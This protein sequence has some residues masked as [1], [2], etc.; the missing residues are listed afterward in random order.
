MAKITFTDISIENLGPFRER[1]TL[2]LSVRDGK[3]VILIK[4]LNG[5]GKTTLLTAIQ[6]ALYGYKA[7]NL[8]R[9]SEYDQLIQSLLRQDA[10]GNAAV[11]V[12]L[13]V[14]MGGRQ[15]PIAVRREWRTSAGNLQES[16]TVS[17]HGMLDM[18]FT[19][20]WDEFINGILPAELVQ[21][22]L[23]DGEKIEALASPDRL[24]DLLRRATEVFLGLGGIDSLATD[25]KA[26]ERRANLRNKESSGEH[27]KLR[28]D[29][30]K[31]AQ[32]LEAT[33]QS[34][35]VLLQQKASLQNTLDVAK[36]ALEHYKLDAQRK[37]L[38]AYEKAAELKAEV[39]SARKRN[40]QAQA[41]LIDAIEDPL[42]PLTWLGPLWDSYKAQW[43]VD[44]Q[45]QNATLLASEFEKRDG[46]LLQ[47]LPLPTTEKQRLAELLQ[48]DLLKFK[49]ENVRQPVLQA[50]GNPHEIQ[51]R[52]EQAVLVLKK[53]VG[54]VEQTKTALSK[55][56]RAVGAIPAEAQLAE[57]LTGLQQRAQVVAKTESD[58]QA[59]TAKLA[60]LQSYVTHTE[61]RLNAAHKRLQEE[62]KDK[63][64]EQHG[65]QAAARAKKAL[66]VFRERLLASKA[67]WLSDMITQSFQQL[68]RKK[69]LVAKVNVDPDTYTVSIIDTAGH[70]LPMERLSAGERQILAIAVLS[71]LI[72]ER[73]GRFP[74]VV[75]TPLARLD[76]KH[77]ES[78]INNFF[79]KVSHQVLVLSTDEEVHGPAYTALQPFMAASMGL[80]FDDVRRSTAVVATE[81]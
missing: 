81:I 11:E 60:E 22:F 76:Q 67:T 62:F 58:L 47:Q 73:K 43:D 74:V 8:A 61:A 12:N 27:A 44:Q 50:G 23:F 13:L 77:R 15:Q 68:L 65:L 31:F 66:L 37:G 39:D 80:A 10:V 21:L 25:L 9:K 5:S 54:Q 57:V 30:E 33:E 63:A 78:L 29:A 14:E 36:S 17:S 6:I 46:R 51:P 72:Q 64:L 79:G 24:P 59:L 71:A 49:A 18:A 38:T 16:M 35:A 1:Q 41:E 56:E 45:V 40:E 53:C 69:R 32:Q 52:L 3:P 7:I 70:T 20:G 42:L 48:A 4:A 34:I 2:P 26:V 55:A 19:E 28:E 75:D